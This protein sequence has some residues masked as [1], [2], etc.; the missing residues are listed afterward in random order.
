MD[1]LDQKTSFTLH[2]L[3]EHLVL[4]FNIP[5]L[6][7]SKKIFFLSLSIINY[8]RKLKEVISL[9]SVTHDE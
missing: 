8:T 2:P 6:N 1:D 7:Y 9:V 4:S 5:N 3:E